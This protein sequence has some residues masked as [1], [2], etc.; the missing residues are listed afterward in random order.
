M[1]L[2]SNRTEKSGLND[3]F[4]LKPE[5]VVWIWSSRID[6]IDARD[7]EGFS[8]LRLGACDKSK[9]LLTVEEGFKLA[10]PEGIVVIGE[11]NDNGVNKSQRGWLIHSNGVGHGSDTMRIH[12]T[13]LLIGE[14]IG[15]P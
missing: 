6:A 14:Y 13:A 3:L 8:W 10:F 4:C 7:R 5:F 12:D 2:F 1:D 15:K 11:F 9:E